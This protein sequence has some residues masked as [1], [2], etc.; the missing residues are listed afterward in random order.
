[1]KKLFLGILIIGLVL[2]AFSSLSFNAKAAYPEKPIMLIVPFSPGG[3]TDIAARALASALTK[4]LGVPVGVENHAG[5]AGAIG[6]LN[7]VTAIP[8]GYTLGVLPIGPVCVAPAIQNVGYTPSDL[9]HIAQF[10]DKVSILIGRPDAPWG[11]LRDL[12]GAAKE[13]PGEITY[14]VPKTAIYPLMLELQ[15]KADVEMQHIPSLGDSDSVVAILGSQVDISVLSDVMV[16]KDHIEAGNMKA[17]AVFSDE[18]S[19]KAPDVPTAKEFGYDITVPLWIGVQAPKETPDNI[20][21]TI[22]E[23]VEKAVVDQDFVKMMQKIGLDIVYLG[24]EEF[25]KRVDIHYQLFKKWK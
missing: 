25:A 17:Y 9:I 20:V 10:S 19:D 11:N 1:M 18:R 14:M 16:A 4:Y 6:T 15:A 3:S 22:E 13:S 7:V 12:I 8:D 2:I 5:G 21:K 23:A 24:K